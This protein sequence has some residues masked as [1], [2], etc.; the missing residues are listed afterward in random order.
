MTSTTIYL[1]NTQSNSIFKEINENNLITERIDSD[2]DG[3]AESVITYNLI[4]DGT[5]NYAYNSRG[6]RISE[7]S[8]YNADG[9]VDRINTYTYNSQGQLLSKSFDDDADGQPENASIYTYDANSN[10][11]SFLDFIYDDDNNQQI[12]DGI[13]NT[14]DDKGNL[15]ASDP[16]GPYGEFNNGFVYNYTYDAKSR[17]IASSFAVDNASGEINILS[18]TTIT[19]DANGSLLISDTEPTYEGGGESF[20]SNTYDAKGRLTNTSEYNAFERPG[21]I[22]NSTYSYDAEGNLISITSETANDSGGLY[23]RTTLNYTYDPEGNLIS[24]NYW[25]G[26]FEGVLFSSYNIKYTYDA[27]AMTQFIRTAS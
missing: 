12:S 13:Y 17:V 23:V 26:S 14:Y 6:N 1:Y 4:N 15:T 2:S 16:Y 21:G 11:V 22:T 7:T 25:E 24:E 9:T 5:T 20:I 18:N 8:D 3:I 19:Y 27:E 10:L